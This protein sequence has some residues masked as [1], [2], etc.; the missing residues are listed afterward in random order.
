ML[1]CYLPNNYLSFILKSVMLLSG[2]SSVRT[3]WAR[4]VLALPHACV[5]L[6]WAAASRWARV[7]TVCFMCFRCMLHMFHS[8]VSSRC[9]KSRS[10][11]AYVA[12]AISVWCKC[13]FQLFFKR[14][15]QVFHLDVTY[16]AM[17]IHYVAVASVSSGCCIC[18]SGYTCTL[19]MC[20]SKCFTVSSRCCTF[21]SRYCICCSG[22]TRMLQLYVLNVSPISDVCCKCFI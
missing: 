10:E 1:D 12:M 16:V 17:T 13:M 20:F 7:A 11:V 18:C 6:Y 14:M 8:H 21:S 19:Q 9:C 22:Y 4:L 2:R 5:N 3:G 15:L